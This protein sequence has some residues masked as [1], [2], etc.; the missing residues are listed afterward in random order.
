MH[1]AFEKRLRR[2]RQMLQTVVSRAVVLLV[3]DIPK[4]QELQVSLY[5][6]E[7]LDG[8]ERF[9]QYGFASHP[10]PGAEA[11]CLSLGGNRDHTVVI[12]VD[13]RRY[14]LHVAEGEVALY[15]DMG[16]YVHLKR[17]GGIDIVSPAEV[18]VAAPSLGL[19]GAVTVTGE[20][21]VAGAFVATSVA[22]E[23]GDLAA[24]RSAYNTHT[25]TDPASGNTGGPS[26]PME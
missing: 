14:R 4:L 3:N 19:T 17:A 13:D 16:N 2:L 8:V 7:T 25:H 22:D 9:Q 23:T 21:T 26:V 10:M 20:L 18:N 15:D 12:A 24:I 5:A 6:D 1:P 11:I